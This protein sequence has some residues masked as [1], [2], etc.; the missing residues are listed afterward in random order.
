MANPGRESSDYRSDQSQSRYLNTFS[1]SP[2]RNLPVP[3]LRPLPPPYAEATPRTVYTVAGGFDFGIGQPPQ[4][5]AVPSSLQR[6]ASMTSPREMTP[7]DGC[8]P[9]FFPWPIYEDY[10]HDTIYNDTGEVV[11]VD[12]IAR[13]EKGFE[14]VQNRWTGYR[15][16][17][18][19][20]S[21][22]FV[23]DPDS[24]GQ[25]LFYNG[26]QIK[27]FGFRICAVVDVN[28][29]RHR[30]DPVELVQFGPKRDAGTRRTPGIVKVAP[31][32][33]LHEIPKQDQ[34]S[35]SINQHPQL[36]THNAPKPKPERYY[37]PILP[38][39]MD[40]EYDEPANLGQENNERYTPDNAPLVQ[41]ST[42][43]GIRRQHCFDRVQFKHATSNNGK[44][45]ATQQYFY[46]RCELYVDVRRN[47]TSPPEWH[48]THILA[49]DQLIIRG[50]SPSHY[51]PGDAPKDPSARQGDDQDDV[52]P[53]KRRRAT[54]PKFVFN[55]QS[56]SGTRHNDNYGGFRGYKNEGSREY[57]M[58]KREEYSNN[59]SASPAHKIE[60]PSEPKLSPS[61]QPTSEAS[62]AEAEVRLADYVHG[63]GD[64]VREEIQYGLEARS[65]GFG[66]FDP[67]NSDLNYRWGA[68][69]VYQPL[70]GTLRDEIEYD[71]L[72]S[73]SV[74]HHQFPRSAAG[75][76]YEQDDTRK[77]NAPGFDE[78][79]DTSANLFPRSLSDKDMPT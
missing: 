78:D 31:A 39:Q 23:L 37:L 32:R 48:M 22:G 72:L 67:D 18:C 19:A 40:D 25:R 16:N 60:S 21:V 74:C 28:G 55:E 66:F 30:G 38:N 17:Y 41:W 36:G 20:P 73:H 79:R 77:F 69:P 11:H 61:T 63:C 2:F 43:D 27:A 34:T 53:T 5:Y 75:L 50:R 6:T 29:K 4:T 70:D 51:R 7:P 35:A 10:S 57:K 12:M 56:S 33:P 49:S 44:R 54:G 14:L 64:D 42:T 46:L 47:N 24:N 8:G 15:R 59:N 58:T 52:P 68:G 9:N 3:D 1:T 13:M 76:Q 71:E 26:K 65:P 62:P 45:R